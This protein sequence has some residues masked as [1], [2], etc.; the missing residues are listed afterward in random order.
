M[1]GSPY[2]KLGTVVTKWL[3][4]VP[5]SQIRCTNKQV[6]DQ[7][8]D[9]VLEDDQVIVSFDVSSLYTNVPVDEA[10]HEAAEL[11]DSGEVAAPPVDKQ[12]FVKSSELTTKDVVMLTH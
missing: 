11:L 6:V 8:K 9:L 10:I 12:T 2:D 1:P 5:A 4:V 3:S 7:I